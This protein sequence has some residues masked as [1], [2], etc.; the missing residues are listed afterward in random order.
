MR[1]TRSISGGVVQKAGPGQGSDDVTIH[2]LLMGL[3]LEWEKDDTQVRSY[4]EPRPRLITSGLDELNTDREA[5]ARQLAR[6]GRT[7]ANLQALAKREA[8]IEESRSAVL[9]AVVDSAARLAQQGVAGGVWPKRHPEI[10]ARD[11]GL[12]FLLNRKAVDQL[13]QDLGE[14]VPRRGR[15][16]VTKSDV[17]GAGSVLLFNP[18]ER[19]FREAQPAFAPAHKIEPQGIKLDWDLEPSWGNS[20]GI[21]HDPEFHLKHYRIVRTIEGIGERRFRAEF[22]VKAA[23]P[24]TITD[25]ADTRAPSAPRICVHRSSL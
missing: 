19:M 1:D 23:A 15:F 16:T 9:A 12:T 6:S 4:G 14:L 13:F 22:M 7:R 17:A 25:D 18:P 8:E 3:F 5:S 24:V 2:T 10:D 20:Q 21:Y 11:F